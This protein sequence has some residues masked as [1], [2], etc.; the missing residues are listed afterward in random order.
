MQNLEGEELLYD[1]I[2]IEKNTDE[3]FYK[4]RDGIVDCNIIGSN[5]CISSIAGSSISGLY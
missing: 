4:K 2:T 5:F 3:E 1:I